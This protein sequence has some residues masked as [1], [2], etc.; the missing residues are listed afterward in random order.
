MKSGSYQ[1]GD[2]KKADLEFEQSIRY[3]NV[4]VGTDYIFFKKGLRW[5]QAEFGDVRR[6]YRRI[7]G[8][9]AKMCCGNVNFDIQKLV[10][11]GK[12]ETQLELL[13][14]EGA[15]READVLEQVIRE[16]HPEIPF[17]KESL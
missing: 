17:G 11:T 12:D 4:K 13:I 15:W 5:Y 8:V 10:R 3:G 16:R 6:A 9:D 2:N 14:G 7:E 1:K